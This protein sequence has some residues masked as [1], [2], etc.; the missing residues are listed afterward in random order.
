MRDSGI[1][2][3]CNEN[4]AILPSAILA[5]HLLARSMLGP[6]LQLPFSQSYLTFQ[7]S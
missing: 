1:S 5:D 6:E 3:N 2:N 7:F 4:L